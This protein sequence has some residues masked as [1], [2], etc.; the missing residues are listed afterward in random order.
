MIRGLLHSKNLL[1]C[2]LAAATGLVLYKHLH[3]FSLHYP[4]HLLLPSA[5]WTVHLR[6]QDSPKHP[7]RLAASLCRPVQTALASG[8]DPEEVTRRTAD[9]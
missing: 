8:D 3:P 4:L 1:A 2:L 5:F 6:P 7:A 9:Y